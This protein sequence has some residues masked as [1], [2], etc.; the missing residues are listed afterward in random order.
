MA[1]PGTVGSSAAEKI[2]EHRR[3]IARKRV[4]SAVVRAKSAA[5]M[6]DRP[7]CPHGA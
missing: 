3:I 2:G 6:V 4:T 5:Q 1:G 7:T